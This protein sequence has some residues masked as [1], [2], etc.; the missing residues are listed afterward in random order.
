M[1]GIV[2]YIHQLIVNVP[3]HPYYHRLRY[4]RGV[5][6]P[7]ASYGLFN[8]RRGKLILFGD[9]NLDIRWI[10]HIN[11]ILKNNRKGQRREG[12]GQPDIRNVVSVVQ[13]RAGIALGGEPRVG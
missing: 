3:C 11:Y 5:E 7:D 6:G 13:W 1:E 12:S 8:A 9:K 10:T 2:A 4:P